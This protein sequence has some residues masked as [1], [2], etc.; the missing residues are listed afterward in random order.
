MYTVK[1]A[2]VA[3]SL[4]SQ[5]FQPSNTSLLLDEYF[6]VCK[7]YGDTATARETH[8]RY[9]TQVESMRGLFTAQS[10]RNS[11]H[12]AFRDANAGRMS[13]TATKTKNAE[14]FASTT[15]A[16]ASVAGRR[17]RAASSLASSAS[18]GE[19][20]KA[21]SGDGERDALPQNPPPPTLSEK[22]TNDVG[23]GSRSAAET[24]PPS[25]GRGVGPSTKMNRA[26]PSPAAAENRGGADARRAPVSLATPAAARRSG[27]AETNSPAAEAN[28]RSA[29]S[30]AI[31][32]RE[33]GHE[34]YEEQF[35]KP[36][37]AFLREL[38]GVMT[39]VVTAWVSDLDECTPYSRHLVRRSNTCCYDA[40][41]GMCLL[42]WNTMREVRAY[43]DALHAIVNAP[44]SAF[45]V[46]LTL[47]MQV[48]GVPVLCMSLAP[49]TGPWQ[50]WDAVTV[51]W[52]SFC[53]LC[54]NLRLMRP[55][56]RA[57]GGRSETSS[58]VLLNRLATGSSAAETG[59]AVSSPWS[60]HLGAAAPAAALGEHGTALERSVAWSL[61]RQ[62][63]PT[64]NGGDYYNASASPVTVSGYDASAHINASG[65][66]VSWEGRR[67]SV[68]RSE[69]T[70]LANSASGMA[71]RV[72]RQ[73]FAAAAAGQGGAFA[74]SGGLQ[75][76]PAIGADA[77]WYFIDARAICLYQWYA[78]SSWVAARVPRREMFHSEN[79]CVQR[80]VGPNK[81]ILQSKLRIMVGQLLN[82]LL[83]FNSTNGNS[84]GVSI[85]TSVPG[86]ILQ[87]GSMYSP[88]ASSSR[89]WQRGKP[90]ILLST[91]C[92]SNGVRYGTYV[93]AIVDLLRTEEESL[94]DAV[95]TA[96]RLGS[97][98]PNKYELLK[99]CRRCIQAVVGELLA[100]AIKHLIYQEWY[101]VVRQSPDWLYRFHTLCASVAEA[102]ELAA[103]LSAAA[104]VAAADSAE[105]QA[106]GKAPSAS[107][108][109]AAEPLATNN[110]ADATQRGETQ[111][112]KATESLHPTAELGCEEGEG[113]RPDALGGV[114]D[115]LRYRRLLT[116]IDETR[117]GLGAPLLDAVRRVLNGVF[118]VN[119]TGSNG[120]LNAAEPNASP[121]DNGAT[122][123]S[124]STGAV[125]SSGGGTGN[126]LEQHTYT[127]PPTP[128]PSSAGGTVNGTGVSIADSSN[129]YMTDEAGRS[130]A[131]SSAQALGGYPV[132]NPLLSAVAFRPTMFD[133]LLLAVNDQYV[134]RPYSGNEKM[135]EWQLLRK[136]APVVT[137][138]SLHARTPPSAGSAGAGSGG[139]VGG[140]GG[141]AAGAAAGTGSGGGG[142][143]SN[144]GSG[145]S[146]SWLGRGANRSGRN[147][148]RLRGAIP[149][150]YPAADE[151][152]IQVEAKDLFPGWSLQCLEEMIGVPL[153]LRQ[154]RVDVDGSFTGADAL[155]A[156]SP[157]MLSSAVASSPVGDAGR[158]RRAGAAL[159]ARA[160]LSAGCP[161][162]SAVW[163]T[164]LELPLCLHSGSVEGALEYAQHQREIGIAIVSSGLSAPYLSHGRGGG[165]AASALWRE[166]N[167]HLVY[168][169]KLIQ[170]HATDVRIAC[171][172]WA[173]IEDFDFLKQ[174]DQPNDRMLGSAAGRPTWSRRRALDFP[175][176][177]RQQLTRVQGNFNSAALAI[178]AYEAVTS[179]G[180]GGALGSGATGGGGGEL[181]LMGACGEDAMTAMAFSAAMHVRL[182]LLNARIDLH[183]AMSSMWHLTECVESMNGSHVVYGYLLRQKIEIIATVA[184][185]F[186]ATGVTTALEAAIADLDVLT[187]GIFNFSSL[188]GVGE[189]A[190]SGSGEAGA[191]LRP[192]RV[193][194]ATAGG[195]RR[196]GGG[197]GGGGVGT[198]GV[199]AARPPPRTP[200]RPAL[201]ATATAAAAT[202]AASTS[203]RRPRLAPAQLSSSHDGLAEASGNLP[204]TPLGLP[205]PTLNPSPRASSAAPGTPLPPPLPPIP[206]PT[207]PPP[208]AATGSS[209]PLLSVD[210]LRSVPLPSPITQRQ[211]AVVAAAVRRSTVSEEEVSN[212]LAISTP[213]LDSRDAA[214]AH[215][216]LTARTLGVHSASPAP[217][218]GSIG[219]FKSFILRSVQCV[220]LYNTLLELLTRHMLL[221][222]AHRT[223]KESLSRAVMFCSLRRELIVMTHG[224]TSVEAAMAAG[225]VGLLLL[226]N[227]KT[228]PQAKME[229]HRAR[230]SLTHHLREYWEVHHTKGGGEGG[231]RGRGRG[232]GANGQ[233]T[234]GG[235]VGA[236]L[237]FE[238]SML[239]TQFSSSVFVQDGR[240]GLATNAADRMREVY[241][242]PL[243]PPPPLAKSAGHVDPRGGH[244][245]VAPQDDTPGCPLSPPRADGHGGG[246]S[247]LTVLRGE[248]WATA[249]DRLKQALCSVL[250][251]IAVLFCR[252]AQSQY[253]LHQ[254][255]MA[256]FVRSARRQNTLHRPVTGLQL[257]ERRLRRAAEVDQFLNEASATLQGVLRHASDVPV[258][259]YAVALNNQA[260]VLLH[261]Y[262]YA[263][264]RLLL[265]QSLH[266][267]MQLQSLS[268]APV[269]LPSSLVGAAGTGATGSV[270]WLL[271]SALL[272]TETATGSEDAGAASQKERAR[273]SM[274]VNGSRG[275]DA[276]QLSGT[277]SGQ[278][279]AA[280]HGIL[281]SSTAAAIAHPTR[282]TSSFS[283]ST[284]PVRAE[285]R[286]VARRLARSAPNALTT[287][288]AMLRDLGATVDGDDADAREYYFSTGAPSPRSLS[289]ALPNTTA[290]ATTKANGVALTASSG[291]SSASIALSTSPITVSEV[292][293]VRNCQVHTLRMLYQLEVQKS[294]IDRLRI[295]QLFSRYLVAWRERRKWRR[296]R[297]AAELYR[298]GAAAMTR[299]FLARRY[300][301]SGYHWW[302]RQ[303]SQV[304]RHLDPQLNPAALTTRRQ[305]WDV[306]N[307]Q[308]ERA[309]RLL[310]RVLRGA[311]VRR[312][313]EEQHEFR[314][315]YFVRCRP[316]VEGAVWRKMNLLY[317]SVLL[318]RH[319]QEGLRG[320][321]AFKEAV[322]SGA[323]WRARVT[324]PLSAQ[325]DV[326][327][328][329]IQMKELL[330]RE[331]LERDFYKTL[332]RQRL[333]QL[334]VAQMKESV[335]L[336]IRSPRPT[337]ATAA[338]V[339]PP[340][341]QQQ[342]Q[343]G[344]DAPAVPLV[345][346]LPL[347]A[348]ISLVPRNETAA[349]AAAPPPPPSRYMDITAALDTSPV[350]HGVAP[351][352]REGASTA[353]LQ[354][355]PV[356]PPSPFSASQIPRVMEG[357]PT[358]LEYTPPAA[359]ANINA[360][361]VDAPPPP[362]AS[363]TVAGAPQPEVASQ[364]V[365]SGQLTPQSLSITSPR[366]SRTRRVRQV[367]I[368]ADAANLDSKAASSPRPVTENEERYQQMRRH[369]R[370]DERAKM[371][372]LLRQHQEQGAAAAA[373]AEDDAEREGP[374]DVDGVRRRER[375]GERSR[376]DHGLGSGSGG[377]QSPVAASAE[378]PNTKWRHAVQRVAEPRSSLRS[379]S[380]P[381][382]LPHASGGG[383]IPAWPSANRDADQAVYSPS[384]RSPRSS[385]PFSPGGTAM[386]LEPLRGDRLTLPCPDSVVSVLPAPRRPRATS[387]AISSSATST[388]SSRVAVAAAEAQRNQLLHASQL[389]LQFW[390]A[391]RA[392][393]TFVASST[394]MHRLFNEHCCAVHALWLR[395]AAAQAAMTP[396]L[397]CEAEARLTLVKAEAVG[398]ASVLLLQ[399]H[400]ARCCREAA[401]HARWLATTLMSEERRGRAA[402][403][404]AAVARER[405]PQ[406]PL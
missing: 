138:R 218:V 4:M 403:L 54:A 192:A 187:G 149:V 80:G 164:T 140:G 398:R 285:E 239:A 236:G 16:E 77:R 356:A 76:T 72:S 210:R 307:A 145:G 133:E 297:A 197:G 209:A 51:V 222:D 390:W 172:G 113:E 357:R 346:P 262:Q 15:A 393:P 143:G 20:A 386:A 173:I 30:Y 292:E 205:T 184:A 148:S 40:A 71:D 339:K 327:R 27:N 94:D 136:R 405:L 200:P 351:V 65:T 9:V 17:G 131:T 24:L 325:Q 316:A 68:F 178:N 225:D 5:R 241:P 328:V 350:L 264:A 43:V 337:F 174:S 22:S 92:H 57:E 216:G 311:A 63:E 286:G 271:V 171:R 315:F 130:L 261:R 358:A 146:D 201:T 366:N 227:P 52:H 240:G 141:G 278:G 211:V 305:L 142:G 168:M 69:P 257:H 308:L 127:A 388:A 181:A 214:D 11:E 81:L 338:L 160:P 46:P 263:Q 53:G 102:D 254:E 170:L 335:L 73:V 119:M 185:Q 349:A 336:V 196:R 383:L 312:T 153:V 368:Q 6:A 132:F 342:Q 85:S 188:D 206:T 300:R 277:S 176:A 330:R 58:S 32:R 401:A 384:P 19:S 152:S 381:D 219:A 134:V 59:T 88:A 332:A 306:W 195:S 310:Q 323:M 371:S 223:P 203:E 249:P 321:S 114:S 118:T 183:E 42:R 208:P 298:F 301:F 37:N 116:F 402:V 331:A 359:F 370:E 125:S 360:I 230:R 44:L 294:F 18:A 41:H 198:G 186:T 282:A 385:S 289:A 382:R 8:Q 126:V 67:N 266:I 379:E 190:G 155:R 273:V 224:E 265:L 137:R 375:D 25:G 36:W 38:A 147:A 242:L 287:I 232:G 234:A 101:M 369:H 250:N 156:L 84:D 365:S 128:H 93:Y 212:P 3:Y 163:G 111:A 318:H 204:G 258:Y 229:F 96:F 162:R 180:G 31:L 12:E 377:G 34:N 341:E 135:S 276:S 389:L 233:L 121:M 95:Q 281:S 29:A 179:G 322:Q 14:D 348:A 228:W 23:E 387:P 270:L 123:A 167:P 202:T 324:K 256:A 107:T 363:T 217:L 124:E 329:G 280:A 252:Q 150:Y 21:E 274:T 175:L 82:G 243:V 194:E 103:A 290:A 165:A 55:L 259:D 399:V 100:R 238:S 283:D 215:L 66:G 70:M 374:E 295:Q 177:Q 391:K 352:T 269:A 245:S 251:N 231:L 151:E 75:L 378:D 99:Q 326:A 291:V 56:D 83:R 108:T 169:G 1:D 367:V 62:L 302:L 115:S 109:P 404:L 106:E 267:T 7:L 50:A 159:A 97:S 279:S 189:R 91:L 104:V 33:W 272:R 226:Q 45:F 345:P 26:G 154:N 120:T 235:S 89:S 87:S 253:T 90:P 35:H 193:D 248:T 221:P 296:A 74:R 334:Q 122:A 60:P 61:L 28:V 213:L 293:Q 49:V 2:S 144:S 314:H 139:G 380:P 333:N 47:G 220:D 376:R 86:G 397:T 247:T 355:A 48:L 207:P 157:S 244:E 343:R 10:L 112:C 237:A 372:Q 105:G 313:L 364:P 347:T 191:F 79:G 78:R 392:L 319:V 373:A 64:A 98:S 299:V 303:P 39:E 246:R 255:S 361:K 406:P 340:Q 260:C 320:M 129:R 275:N 13:G 117:E 182:S 396:L 304:R 110:A 288:A 166:R 353:A 199:V 354:A 268:V 317:S 161:L 394:A 284:A 309:A 400:G 395:E 344:A 362:P 158:M